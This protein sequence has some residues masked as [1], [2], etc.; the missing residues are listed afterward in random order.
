[1]TAKQTKRYL[2]ASTFKT[3][4]QSIYSFK[5]NNAPFK[6]GDQTRNLQSRE[7]IKSRVSNLN[8]DILSDMDKVIWKQVKPKEQEMVI[9]NKSS[10]K[11]QSQE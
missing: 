6:T 3:P 11:L 8:D 1:M 4:K 9:T 5:S 7:N 2:D 10:R